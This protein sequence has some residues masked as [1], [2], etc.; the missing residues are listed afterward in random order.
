MDA[1]ASVKEILQGC[2]SIVFVNARSWWS[3]TALCSKERNT[4]AA[5]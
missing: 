2:T 4:E 5:Q 1:A 3:F